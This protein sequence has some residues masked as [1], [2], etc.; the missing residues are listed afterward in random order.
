MMFQAVPDSP[1]DQTE[2]AY[3]AAFLCLA[4]SFSPR[5]AQLWVWQEVIP[6][7]KNEQKRLEDGIR[8]DIGFIAAKPVVLEQV[9]KHFIGFGVNQ[10]RLP[11]DTG[12]RE[13]IFAGLRRIRGK[14]RR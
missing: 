5:E 9:Q 2:A 11:N 13:A 14:P 6:T 7:T 4:F 10:H 8:L 1:I 3:I 12:A